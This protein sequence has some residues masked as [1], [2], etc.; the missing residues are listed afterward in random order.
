MEWR[1][2]EVFVLTA[3]TKDVEKEWSLPKS[4]NFS[5]VPFITVSSHGRAQNRA[6][7]CM[8]IILDTVNKKR[9]FR[10]ELE[11]RTKVLITS[12]QRLKP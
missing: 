6:M 9:R 12:I 4:S 2:C 8:S 10:Y 1:T 7:V 5:H 11:L 3:S